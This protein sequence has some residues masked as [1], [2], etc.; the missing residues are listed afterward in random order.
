MNVCSSSVYSGD[1]DENVAEEQEELLAVGGV[2][3]SV[4]MPV[5]IASEYVRT[6]FKSFKPAVFF[7][8]SA[9][10]HTVDTTDFLSWSDEVN[11]KIASYG[12]SE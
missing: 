10:L 7:Q 12:S 5:A 9:T 2:V 11:W 1:D 3:V 8:R 4:V 6:T